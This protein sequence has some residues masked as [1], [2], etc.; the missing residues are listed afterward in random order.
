MYSTYLIT[1][2]TGDSQLTFYLASKRSFFMY[3]QAKNCLFTHQV[4]HNSTV[5]KKQ[6]VHN[7]ISRLFYRFS[8]VLAILCMFY[9]QFSSSCS[10]DEAPPQ[11]HM[12]WLPIPTSTP[13]IQKCLRPFIC[14]GWRDGST[15][16]PLPPYLFDQNLPFPLMDSSNN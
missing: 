8:A 9:F 10:L 4:T 16:T 6:Q 1:Y 15:I 13:Y 2:W 5:I 12:E 3:T 14:C 11:T 7:A